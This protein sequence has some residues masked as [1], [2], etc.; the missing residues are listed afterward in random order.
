[1]SNSGEKHTCGDRDIAAEK[2]I[3]GI[4]LGSWE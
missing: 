2:E 1:M 3:C 4:K